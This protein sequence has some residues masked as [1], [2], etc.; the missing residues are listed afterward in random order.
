ME[1]MRGGRRISRLKRILGASFQKVGDG[2]Q[3]GMARANGDRK[4]L[5]GR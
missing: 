3:A 2:S 5:R 4:P 1:G